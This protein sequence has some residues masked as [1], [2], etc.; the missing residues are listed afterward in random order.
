MKFIFPLVLTAIGTG[1]GVGAG[2]YLPPSTFIDEAD[3]SDIECPTPEVLADWEPNPDAETE[4]VKLSNQL[5]VPVVSDRG[6]NA[7]VILSIS[8]EV[9]EL[10]KELVFQKE[11]RL[12]DHLLQVLFSHANQG[13]FSGRYT[14][15]EKMT[16]L[17]RRLSETS[18]KILGASLHDVL[19]TDLVRQAG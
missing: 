9:D 15:S 16:Q 4:F 11:P 12:R 19:I 5:V 10:G 8:F 14:N 7:L 18:R 6:D 2:L 13:G 3:A 17:R 1:A